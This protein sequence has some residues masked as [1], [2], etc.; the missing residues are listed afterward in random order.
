MARLFSIRSI[1]IALLEVL[2][3]SATA[4]KMNL[5]GRGSSQGD[6]ERSHGITFDNEHRH[7]ADRA[8]EQLKSEGLIRSTYRD[9]ID[10]ES[11]VEITD[12]GRAAL[13]RKCIDELDGALSKISPHLL[14]LREG[15]WA[16]LASNQTDTLRQASHSAREL[17]DQ[18]LKEGAPD[19]AVTQMAGFVHDPKSTSG[20]TR[21]HRI[22]YLMTDRRGRVSDADLKVIEKACELV[23]ATSARLTA[24]SHSR[25]TLDAQNTKDMVGLA[26]IALRCVL[27]NETV[28]SNLPLNPDA[29]QERPRAG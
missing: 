26:E 29:R 13:K 28:P 9:L 4:H 6:V 15:A 22:K 16:A 2:N 21:R 14:E 19:A 23:D 17:L 10:P 24:D 20:I 18:T 5:I 8:F 12:S 27:L 25:T 3:S 7:L 11:W 1:K